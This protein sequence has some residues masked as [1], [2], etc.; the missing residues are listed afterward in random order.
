MKTIHSLQDLQKQTW[1]DLTNVTCQPLLSIFYLHLKV[2]HYDMVGRTR[3][4]KLDLRFYPA[5]AP[6]HVIVSKVLH[7]L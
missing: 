6:N 5:S 1:Q 3:S 4:L 2:D 7:L